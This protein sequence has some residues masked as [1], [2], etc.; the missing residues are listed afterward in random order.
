MNMKIKFADIFNDQCRDD[1][2]ITIKS[3]KEA[4]ESPLDKQTFEHNGLYLEFYTKEIDPKTL[5]LLI[6]EKKMKS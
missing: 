3:A 2:K 5:L 4:I 6:V 1:F